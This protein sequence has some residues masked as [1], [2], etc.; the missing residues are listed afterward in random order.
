MFD[1]VI[2]MRVKLVQV[3][4]NTYMHQ[5]QYSCVICLAKVAKL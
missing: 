2:P 1:T 5:E 4:Q 3:N